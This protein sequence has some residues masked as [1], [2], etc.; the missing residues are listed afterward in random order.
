M[1]P[2]TLAKALKIRTFIS[3]KVDVIKAEST[4]KSSFDGS[5]ISRKS[6]LKLN[7]SFWIWLRALIFPLTNRLVRALP[8]PELG[9]GN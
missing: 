7:V 6:I 4:E 1:S 3:R 9:E 5:Q 8:H 2:E